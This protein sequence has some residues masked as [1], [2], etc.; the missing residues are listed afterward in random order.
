MVIV[1]ELYDVVCEW[2]C[3]GCDGGCGSCGGFV[4]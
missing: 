4:C 3:S 2:C 1:F